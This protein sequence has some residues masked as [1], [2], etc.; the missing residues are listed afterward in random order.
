[1]TTDARQWLATLFQKEGT[2][3]GVLAVSLVITVLAAYI[4]AEYIERRAEERFAFEVEDARQRIAR[5]MVTYEQVLRS[6][7]ALFETLDGEVTRG[8]WRQYIEGLQIEEHFPGIQGVGFAVM[9]RPDELPGHVAAVRAEGFP[10]YR[11]TPTGERE[12]YS[13]IVYLE[14]F[15]A[16]NRRA[17]GF[18]MFSQPIRR[19]AMEQ[20]RDTGLPTV[21]GRVRLRQETG[22]D[23]QPGFLMYLPVYAPGL[24]TGTAEERA[25]ALLGFVYSPFR[26]HDLMHGILGTAKPEV[27]FELY[28]AEAP[29][30]SSDLLYASDPA[31][32]GE[33]A[34]FQTTT[35]ITLPGRIWTA[36]FHSTPSFDTAASSAQPA[37]IAFG[38]FAV[39]LLLFAVI[40]S[41][42]GERRRVQRKAEAMTAELRASTQRLRESE[43]RLAFGEEMARLGSWRRNAADGSAWW[44]DGFYRLLG[45]EPQG[46]Q[47]SAERLHEFLPAPAAAQVDAAISH[48]LASGQV[49]ELEHPIRRANGDERVLYV[50]LGPLHDEEGRLTGYVGTALDITER[51]RAEEALLAEHTLL[52]SIIDTIPDLVVLKDTELVYRNVNAAFLRFVGKPLDAVVGRSDYELFPGAEAEQYRDDDRL[53]LTTGQPL[54]R[55]EHVTGAEGQRWFQVAKVPLMNGDGGIRGVLMSV[56]D[57]SALKNAEEGLRQSQAELEQRVEE[58]TRELELAYK[59]LETFSYT[60]SHDLRAPLRAIGGFTQ[61]LAEDCSDDLGPAGQGY[62]VQ[63]QNA[64]A[65]MGALIDGLLKLSRL[66][67]SELQPARV[68]LGALAAE[69]VGLLRAADPERAVDITIEPGLEAYGDPVLLRAALQNLLD[70]AWKFTRQRA[71]ARIGV[72]RLREAGR[73]VYYVSDNGAGFDAQHAGRLFRPFER[74]HG[75]DTFEGTG[76][77]LATVRRIIQRHGGEVWSSGAPGEGAT[78]YFTLQPQAHYALA[79]ARQAGEPEVAGAGGEPV[80]PR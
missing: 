68:D 18:D 42:A 46:F 52:Q 1:M 23:L 49:T 41:L 67:R 48:V 33:A 8:Q 65:R 56:R 58:R 12:A 24:P 55:I 43:G 30:H 75:N 25:A 3:R 19:T 37:L 39:D 64:V 69:I 76:I 51:K 77:G 40:H 80:E 27:A 79:A 11:V 63:V 9:L 20:A 54:Q 22:E 16:R 6:G 21:S 14:P 29:D 50:R 4:T 13:A 7:V 70:N 44:S 47:P 31:T 57:I 34:A 26:I 38:G 73:D 15:D 72:G 45:A 59:E 71:D 53:V 61:M 35:T 17:F 5:R 10:D 28:D 62:V 74:L 60:V 36:R 78:F 32:S 2:A 66:A